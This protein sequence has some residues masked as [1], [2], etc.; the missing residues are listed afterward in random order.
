M[1]QMASSV[2]V[3]TCELHI[4]DQRGANSFLVTAWKGLDLAAETLASLVLLKFASPTPIQK[5][6]IPHILNGHDLIGKAPTGSGKT[7][8]FGIPI[9]EYYL[10]MQYGKEHGKERSSWV[11]RQTRRHPPVALILSPTRELAHQISIHLADLCRRDEISGPAVAT[12]TGGL[13]ILKQNR[14]LSN[15]DIIVA[16]PGRLWEVMEQNPELARSLKKIRFLV[17]DEAD[18]LLTDGKFMELEQ[19][20][21]A[22]DR[23][24]DASD[25]INAE[26]P[27]TSRPKEQRQTLVFSATFQK[28]LQQKLAG[29]SKSLGGYPNSKDISLE[30]LL[31]K[32][33]FRE[34]KPIFIDVNPASQMAQGLKEGLVECDGT[35]KVEVGRNLLNCPCSS[36]I[37][38][39]LPLLASASLSGYSHPN[40]SVRSCLCSL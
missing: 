39:S 4:I 19:I 2:M 1:G 29:K 20:L 37:T 35:E 23:E 21:N 31:A 6:S 40:V 32:L 13:S 7:L 17:I 3:R 22:L 26:S 8:A 24:E 5:A 12:V 34:Q 10:E 27:S 38:G 25:E 18:R 28:E 11:K 36:R 30:Y 16:T 14:L 15:A 9:F 33:N